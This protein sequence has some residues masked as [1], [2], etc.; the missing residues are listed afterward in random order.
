M[1]SVFICCTF[2]SLD[3]KMPHN[4]E[5]LGTWFWQHWNDVHTIADYCLNAT[6]FSD[7]GSVNS[8]W[9]LD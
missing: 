5:N 8:G 4:E 7:K 1:Y 3:R 9:V 2:D 6:F